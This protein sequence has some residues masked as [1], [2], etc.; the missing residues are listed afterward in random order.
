MA[1]YV[2][3]LT[4]LTAGTRVCASL[5]KYIPARRACCQ[6]KQQGCHTCSAC[7]CIICK[8]GLRAKTYAGPGPTLRTV[9]NACVYVYVDCS[10]HHAAGRPNTGAVQ[11]YDTFF[12]FE[13]PSF[14]DPPGPAMIQMPHRIPLGFHGLFV[15]QDELGGKHV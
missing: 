13:D 9:P 3:T 11:V 5:Q 2:Q 7:M 1:M 12:T 10:P 15:R 6:A 14:P 4:T 8:Q